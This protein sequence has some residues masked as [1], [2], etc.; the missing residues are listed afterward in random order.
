MLHKSTIGNLKR[1][2]RAL[3]EQWGERDHVVRAIDLILTFAKLE[4]LRGVK[5]PG[6]GSPDESP[7]RA[8]SSASMKRGPRGEADITGD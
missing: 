2:R 8:I 6:A 7:A 4:R 1:E 5:T 3:A